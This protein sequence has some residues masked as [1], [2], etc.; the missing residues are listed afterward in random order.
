MD[1][2]FIGF[3]AWLVFVMGASGTCFYAK[4]LGWKDEG[5]FFVVLLWFVACPF[6][7]GSMLNKS[8]KELEG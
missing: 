4:R 5:L 7:I 6:V 1:I 2:W 3:T 8:W